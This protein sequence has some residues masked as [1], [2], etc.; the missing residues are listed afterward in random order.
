MLTVAACALLASALVVLLVKTRFT[1]WALVVAGLAIAAIVLIAAQLI[2]VNRQVRASDAWWTEE[3][4]T[5][6]RELESE[7]R[8]YRMKSADSATPRVAVTL[9][10]DEYRG[11]LSQR[12]R[13]VE[14]CAPSTRSGWQALDCLPPELNDRTVQTVERAAAAIKGRTVCDTRAQ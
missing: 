1:R 6:A 4:Q 7:A 3:C 11:A 12:L 10:E 13:I 9:M 5:V 8:G 2:R 14:I